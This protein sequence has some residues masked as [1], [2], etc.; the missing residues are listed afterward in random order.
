MCA[1]K[2]RG[3][4]AK[5]FARELCKRLVDDR[6][7]NEGAM[8]AYYTMMAM[9]PMLVSVVALAMLA[10]PESVIQQGVQIASAAVPPAVRDPLVDRITLF[11]HQPHGAFAFLG[12]LLALSSARG[13]L[14]SLMQALDTVFHA[15]E[16][17]SWLR[18]QVVA[19]ALALGVT[20]LAVLALGLLVVGPIAGHW[21]ADRFGASAAFIFTWSIARWVGTVLLVL[22][23]WALLYRFL[24]DTDRPFRLLTPGAVSGVVLWLGASYGFSAYVA[25]F[26]SYETTYG[27]LGGAFIFLTWLWLSNI[28]LLFGAEVNAVLADLRQPAG[29]ADRPLHQQRTETPAHA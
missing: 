7:L 13:G 2:T 20:L 24:P 8:M 16:T 3:V 19:L 10:L 18:R 26:H 23:V 12:G 11:M 4:Q 9:F 29:L 1:A 22:L 17:R 27:A 5:R 15:Q 6:V 28:A 14:T 21:V 25:H